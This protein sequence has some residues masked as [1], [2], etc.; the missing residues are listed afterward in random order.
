MTKW[1]ITFDVLWEHG[2]QPKR[3]TIRV[4]AEEKYV[5]QLA[6]ALNSCGTVSQV[7]IE[8]EQA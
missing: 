7:K 2:E 8:K 6:D 1:C 5:I 3:Q 4:N